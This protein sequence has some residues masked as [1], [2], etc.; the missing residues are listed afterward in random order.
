MLTVMPSKKCKN[1]IL[2]TLHCRLSLKHT[3]FNI[4]SF[5]SNNSQRKAEYY[6]DGDDSD[7]ADD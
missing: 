1:L 2:T 6:N 4:T 5:K 7:D 3:I